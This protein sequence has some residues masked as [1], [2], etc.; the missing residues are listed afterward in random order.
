M[1]QRFSKRSRQIHEET[2]KRVARDGLRGTLADVREQVAHDRRRRKIQEATADRLR[3]SWLEQLSAGERP[4]LEMLDLR[5]KGEPRTPA[6]FADLLSWSARHV[7]E[8]NCVVAEHQVLAA[9]LTRGRG[10]EFDLPALRDALNRTPSIFAV[11]EGMVT[12]R[13][14]VRLEEDFVRLA[15]QR[16]AT[17]GAINY[18]FAPD[19]KLSAEQRRAVTKLMQSNSFITLLRGAAGTGKTVALREVQR[20]VIEAK[21]PWIVLA[22]QR[23]QVLDLQND[24]LPARTVAE[25]LYAAEKLSPKTVILRNGCRRSLLS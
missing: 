13:E 20:G 7:F 23:Q 24:G 16:T 6:D 9:A 21:R 8:R 5:G 11:N 4:S 25:F 22:P 18:H 10:Q 3:G 12:S 17:E 1:I 15:M 2:A 19:P 14:L